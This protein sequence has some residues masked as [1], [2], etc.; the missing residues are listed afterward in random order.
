MAP[1]PDGRG[2]ARAF[3]RLTEGWALAGG[4]LLLAVVAINGWSVLSDALLGRPFPG[5]FELTEIGV[6]V[7]VFAFLPYCQLTGGNVTA[8]VFTARAGPRA[9]AALAAGAACLALGLSGLLLW[10]MALGAVDMRDAKL[11]TTILQL[12]V[13]TAF[14][15]ITASLVLLLAA[16]AVTL[17]RAL[18]AARR[19]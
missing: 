18:G 14:V 15:P 7:A 16:A 8:E 10:R 13:W 17:A 11:V 3:E 2:G 19:G 12:P 5:A 6:A 4:G 1:G 9:R